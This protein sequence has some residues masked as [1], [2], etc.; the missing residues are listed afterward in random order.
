LKQEKEE[1]M[2]QL[3]V[4]QSC[5]NTYEKEKD[6]IRAMFEEEKVKI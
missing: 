5:A 4:A 3:R 1:V 6:E 2:E